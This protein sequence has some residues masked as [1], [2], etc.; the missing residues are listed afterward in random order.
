MRFDIITIFPELFTGAL[1][2]GIIRRAR[3]AGLV[4]VRLVN[5]RDF[6]RDRHRSVDDRPYGGGEGMVFMPGACI[7][8]SRLP[9][10][11]VIYPP[12]V[13]QLPLAIS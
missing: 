4:D 10:V 5:L 6:A 2:C 7:C 3:Q 9:E 12:N 8:Q 11:K 1:E 13:M